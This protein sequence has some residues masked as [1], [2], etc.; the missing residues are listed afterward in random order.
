MISNPTI[1]SEWKSESLL[2]FLDQDHRNVKIPFL[3]P[4][5]VDSRFLKV[6]HNIPNR[7]L[8]E[9]SDLDRL[10]AD[11]GILLDDLCV[12]PRQDL[13]SIS[14]LDDLRLRLYGDSSLPISGGID[15][16][17]TSLRRQALIERLSNSRSIIDYRLQAES[18]LQ[19]GM[20]CGIFQVRDVWNQWIR[21]LT[22]SVASLSV[23]VG[24]TPEKLA[25]ILCVTVVGEICRPRRVFETVFLAQKRLWTNKDISG[26]VSGNRAPFVQIANCVANAVLF[27]ARSTRSPE[28]K[29]LLGSQLLEI[30]LSQCF[31]PK[32][33][34]DT[35]H[36]IAHAF[37]HTVED[38]G[39]KSVGYISLCPEFAG[40]LSEILPPFN[41]QKLPPMVVPPA[42]WSG[43]WRCG[44]VVRRHAL[45]RFTGMNESARDVAACESM[46]KV[47][48]GLDFL[49]SVSW[50][51]NQNVLNLLDE[52]IERKIP[53]PGVPP[54]PA[55]AAP[56]AGKHV[57]PTDRLSLLQD[58]RAAEKKTTEWP[59][60]IGRISVA[61]D[62]RKSEQIYFPHSI[63]FRGRAYPIPV[64][65]NHQG[66]DVARSLLVW[67]T[68]KPLGQSGW[69]WLRIHAAN[70]FGKDKM[71]FANRVRWTDDNLKNILRVAKNPLECIEWINSHTEDFWQSVAVCFEIANAVESGNPETFS[72][73]LPIYQDG[74]CN[75]L[76]HYA[77][78]GR[79]AM[80]AKA[81]NVSGSEK[82][83]D[84]YTVVLEIVKAQIFAHAKGA[85]EGRV[86]H[87]YTDL[88][89]QLAARQNL[90]RFLVN[91]KDTILQRKIVKQ[92][93]M[94]ICYGVTLMGA[95]DQI[96]SQLTALPTMS[97]S[98]AQQAVMARYLARL[99][100]SSIGQVFSEAMAIRKWFDSVAKVMNKHKLSINWMSPA[101][102]PCRQPYRK[103]A[104][105]EIRTR[106]QKVKIL[107]SSEKQPISGP[108]QKMGFPPNFVHSLDGAHMLR[109]ALACKDKQI[110]FA[111]VHDS[112]WTHACDVE[113]MNETIRE[114]FF[115]M[116]DKQ[117][118]LENLRNSIIT[119]LG[120]H[121]H[122][123]PPLPKQGKLDLKCVLNSPYFFD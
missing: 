98:A 61:R 119:Q 68:S 89:E 53:V 113:T 43:F 111:A 56:P 44:Y 96:Y 41:F 70:L 69:R 72:S 84:V 104:V 8:D 116:Y 115:K 23:S 31:F 110:A 27:E 76:Q 100:L 39:F 75:G 121:G 22:A 78:L 73:N 11:S 57:L 45:V 32:P 59:A 28:E 12:L 107:K 20:L 16:E 17:S 94:T 46:G 1:V 51:I 81:V 6:W 52:V 19:R 108:K 64:P 117:P 26:G 38:R 87:K 99:I 77:A 37:S 86:P 66:D 5:T 118:I 18:M 101:G 35:Q 102:V 71:T 21:S 82:V 10:F 42:C 74:S 33:H 55:P 3:D 65:F 50:R 122:N 123:I 112:Y 47:R 95:S 67:G 88:T 29:I 14:S 60:F 79:D 2:L 4:E 40:I 80:G 109:T 114:E 58:L 48:T 106:V 120:E 91:H 85:T 25:T 49:G 24:I 36:I 13:L 63:D 90:A 62:F 103:Q 105:T 92:T 7:V 97:I 9:F 30:L 93:V 83:E 15:A 54:K 34:S